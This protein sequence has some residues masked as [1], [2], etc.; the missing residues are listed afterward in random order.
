MPHSCLPA[1]SSSFVGSGTDEASFLSS[2]GA[3]SAGLAS[4]S[5]ASFS[6]VFAASA[7]KNLTYYCF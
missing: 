6:A 4:F 7:E 5:G 3:A 1:S 2:T